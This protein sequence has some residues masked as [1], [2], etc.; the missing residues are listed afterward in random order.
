MSD[1]TETE[2]RVPENSAEFIAHGRSDDGSRL[3]ALTERSCCCPSRP[4]VRVLIPSGSEPAEGVDLLLCGHH[5]RKSRSALAAI[6]AQVTFLGI[7]EAT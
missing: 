7:G 4:A 6:G 3:M 2:L 1:N 5:Y